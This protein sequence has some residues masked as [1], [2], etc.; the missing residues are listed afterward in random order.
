MSCSSVRHTFPMAQLTEGWQVEFGSLAPHD[1]DLML[2]WYR[3]HT[4]VT[5]A[6]YPCCHPH[7]TPTMKY[8][9]L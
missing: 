9:G 8:V 2:D 1:T 4:T 5:L 7:V 6:R 3:Q